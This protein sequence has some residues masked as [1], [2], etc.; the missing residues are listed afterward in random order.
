MS[1]NKAPALPNSYGICRQ[2]STVRGSDFHAWYVSITRHGKAYQRAFPFIAYEGELPALKM[3]TAYRD[4]RIRLIPPQTTNVLRTVPSVRSQ[5]SIPGVFRSDDGKKLVWI[6]AIRS[7]KRTLRRK[8]SIRLCGEEGARKRA[9]QAREEFMKD[10]QNRFF[11]QNAGATQVAS[12]QFAP[13]L[14]KSLNMVTPTDAEAK[15]DEKRLQQNVGRLN[16]WF[17]AMYPHYV[18]VSCA[19][20]HTATK[21]T[22]NVSITGHSLGIAPIRRAWAIGLRDLVEARQLAWDFV[23][24]TLEQLCGHAWCQAFSRKYRREFMEVDENHAADSRMR[25]VP[26]ALLQLTHPPGVLAEAL[27][28]FT[29]APQC[30]GLKAK[31]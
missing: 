27:P 29:I 28:G 24:T 7:N 15:R 3:A 18:R 4:A 12:S 1:A 10:V 11:T 25:F 16:R 14:H 8:F 20:S 2:C 5:S 30:L 23:R 22:F 6:A 9:I 13:M 19:C 21:H 26:N 31:Q 17:D